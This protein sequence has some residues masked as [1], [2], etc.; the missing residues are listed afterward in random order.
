V[1]TFVYTSKPSRQENLSAGGQH[2][3]C[4]SQLPSAR[5]SPSA[6]S[7]NPGAKPALCRCAYAEHACVR[8]GLLWLLG[9]RQ[10]FLLWTCLSHRRCRL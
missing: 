7:Q 8:S 4:V 3:E 6:A 5:A 10:G 1:Y 2:V 9:L